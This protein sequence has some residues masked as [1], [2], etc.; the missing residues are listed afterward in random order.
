VVHVVIDSLPIHVSAPD[1]LTHSCIGLPS[2]LLVKMPDTVD[3]GFLRNGVFR[4]SRKSWSKR[5]ENG[6]FVFQTHSKSLIGCIEW[7][8]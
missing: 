3:G 5:S 4:G 2:S 7:L 8:L 6:G 1:K